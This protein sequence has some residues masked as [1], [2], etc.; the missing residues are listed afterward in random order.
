M[1]LSWLHWRVC[2]SLNGECRRQESSAAAADDDDDDDDDDVVT[3]DT[4]S[5]KPHSVTSTSYALQ[6]TVW[7]ET[8][9]SLP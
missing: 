1:L 7:L 3:P 4:T 5:L 9:T 2:T 6:F 8:L